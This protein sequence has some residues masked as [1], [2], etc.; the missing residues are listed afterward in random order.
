MQYIHNNVLE[1]SSTPQQNL[2]L[3]E[4]LQIWLRDHFIWC[5]ERS[6]HSLAHSLSL[7]RFKVWHRC[8]GVER[9]EAAFQTKPAGRLREGGPPFR[10][11]PFVSESESFEESRKKK[12]KIRPRLNSPRRRLGA[13]ARWNW[14]W[15]S[16]PTLPTP[17]LQPTHRPLPSHFKELI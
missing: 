16:I 10:W 2:A 3:V 1:I 6:K 8:G 5:F 11:G 13:A 14:N 17:T 7:G 4:T 15:G 9:Y 12:K